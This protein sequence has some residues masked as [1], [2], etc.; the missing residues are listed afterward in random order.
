MTIPSSIM[1]DNDLTS[2]LEPGQ[3]LAPERSF[4]A[5]ASVYEE[6]LRR[7]SAKAIFDDL[8]NRS[9]W[10]LNKKIFLSKFDKVINHSSTDPYDELLAAG[11]KLFERDFNTV[12][13][14]R[15]E[16]KASKLVE[17][18]F[19]GIH[20]DS[21]VGARGRTETHRLIYYPNIFYSDD[22]RGHLL[23]H[24]DEDRVLAGIRPLFNSCVA[25]ELSDHSLHS[26]SRLCCGV[27][28]TVSIL[29]W[30]YPLLFEAHEERLQIRGIVNFL[31]SSGL[32]VNDS[33][34]PMHR[35]HQVFSNLFHLGARYE[36]CVAGFISSV[37]LIF[38]ENL[39]HNENFILQIWEKLSE[40]IKFA[41]LDL[42]ERD[43]ELNVLHKDELALFHFAFSLE[44]AE[45]SDD[46]NAVESEL[47]YGVFE[48]SSIMT[49]ISSFC[50]DLRGNVFE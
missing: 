20:N 33:I 8:S 39:L 27:R 50:S 44:A 4:P 47:R 34:S 15:Y 37:I 48:D 3:A 35:T 6:L 23:L 26:V 31:I 38:D 46:V 42:I 9:D 11:R 18:Q 21:P 30:G 45:S 22:M 13:G 16:I 40:E 41:T 5:F 1:S 28:F 24:D 10:V 7:S 25:M 19:L 43:K 32:E 29:Y 2:L 36:L 17:G 49:R 14:L 12:I